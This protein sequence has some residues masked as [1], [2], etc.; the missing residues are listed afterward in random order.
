M[1]SAGSPKIRVYPRMANAGLRTIPIQAGKAAKT[2]KPV[3]VSPLWGL[4]P[5][6]LISCGIFHPVSR[7]T[8]LDLSKL[9]DHCLACQACHLHLAG[10]DMH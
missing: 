7:W 1:F 8:A 10:T 5:Q 6:S 9:P 2:A 4:R 3:P